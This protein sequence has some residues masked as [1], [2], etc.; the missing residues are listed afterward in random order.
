MGQANRFYIGLL[1]RFKCYWTSDPSQAGLPSAETHHALAARA[2]A[3]LAD[4]RTRTLRRA[5]HRRRN[6]RGRGL[7]GLKGVG[8]LYI[9]CLG[10]GRPRGRNVDCNPSRFAV[11]SCHDVSP[12]GEPRTT[13]RR[14]DSNSASVCGVSTC[15]SQRR[16]N[17]I[18]P[19]SKSPALLPCTRCQRLDHRQAS[20]FSTM[21]A[22][23]GF[24]ST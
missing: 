20:A 9:D 17:L 15:C 10:H 22:R 5:S 1:C 7:K 24:R 2:T 12:N 18:G 8:C 3:S 23:S 4:T 6:H 16:G 21:F 19:T 11:R 13:D 14:N